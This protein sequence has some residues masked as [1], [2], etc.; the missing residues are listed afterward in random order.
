[1]PLPLSPTCRRRTLIAARALSCAA[2]FL[3]SSC[4]PEGPSAPLL[5]SQ[6]L[7]RRLD[8]LSL[9]RQEARRRGLP[10]AL[11]EHQYAAAADSLQRVRAGSIPDTALSPYAPADDTGRPATGPDLTWLLNWAVIALCAGALAAVAAVSA[12]VLR[13]ARTRKAPRPR[14]VRR[15]RKP[16]PPQVPEEMPTAEKTPGPPQP[17]Y[18]RVPKAAA[19][20]PHITRSMP[21]VP[22]APGQSKPKL[23]PRGNGGSQAQAPKVRGP[24]APAPTTTARPSVGAQRDA[25]RTQQTA[26]RQD[27]QAAPREGRA[28]GESPRGDAPRPT[29]NHRTTPTVA[30]RGEAPTGAARP[31]AAE[32]RTTEQQ[33]QGTQA[34]RAAPVPPGA[35]AAT[36]PRRPAKQ[37]RPAPDELPTPAPAPS[38]AVTPQA[39]AGRTASG[40]AHSDTQAS[41]PSKAP[42]PEATVEPA[43]S[44]AEQAEPVSVDG[45]KQQVLRAAG[46]KHSAEQIAAELGLSVDH[47][48]LI[49]KTSAPQRSP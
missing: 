10:V 23:A 36:E 25:P 17:I 41:R 26:R 12:S 48:R 6:R 7:L 46:G 21:Q 4:V 27:P 11:L 13:R 2:L 1:M 19:P 8:S 20:S 3:A 44:D 5:P 35:P 29:A 15:R 40:S 38:P 45:L 9:Q 33:V 37:Y 24:A 49:L 47:V 14:S 28:E 30:P 34:A 43:A 42:G 22:G 39:R 32:P 16:V 31:R 18:R